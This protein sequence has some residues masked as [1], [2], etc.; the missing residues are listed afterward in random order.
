MSGEVKLEDAAKAERAC[1]KLLKKCFAALDLA[2]SALT[3]ELAPWFFFF[4]LSLNVT[5][6]SQEACQTIYNARREFVQFQLSD[7]TNSSNAPHQIA[8]D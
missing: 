7:S 3:F 8:A 6:M 2:V 4:A 1:Q 5:K